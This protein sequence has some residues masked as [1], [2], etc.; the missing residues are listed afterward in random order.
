MARLAIT[1]VISVA[2]LLSA[3]F[4]GATF[5]GTDGGD[6]SLM[7]ACVTDK[8]SVRIVHPHDVC[9]SKETPLHWP[10]TSTRFHAV[11][12]REDGPPATFGDSRDHRPDLRPL[13]FGLTG[14]ADRVPVCAGHQRP[15]RPVSL[16][17]GPP[18]SL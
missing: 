18:A 16:R 3:L 10:A 17:C 2:L 12:A 14:M 11:I 13:L 4:S 7:H 5:V 8:G 9:A 15:G 1:A 6:S